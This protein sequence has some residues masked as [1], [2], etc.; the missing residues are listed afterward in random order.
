LVEG[1]YFDLSNWPVCCIPQLLAANNRHA[2]R[3][4]LPICL[5]H[6]ALLTDNPPALVLCAYASS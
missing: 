6:S 3:T 2:K 1:N 5:Y 4:Y